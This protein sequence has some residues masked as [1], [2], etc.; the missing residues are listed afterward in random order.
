MKTV[1]MVENLTQDNL[2]KI[3]NMLVNKKKIYYLSEKVLKE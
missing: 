2:R 3:T 1:V